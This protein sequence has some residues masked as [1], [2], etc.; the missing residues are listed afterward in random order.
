MT[1]ADFDLLHDFV[2]DRIAAEAFP[3]LESL[4]RANGDDFLHCA[5]RCTG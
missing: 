2:A 3:R 5:W 1:Q 4:L